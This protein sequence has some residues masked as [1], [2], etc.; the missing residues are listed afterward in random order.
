MNNLVLS[1]KVF[2]MVE[3]VLDAE[4][5]ALKIKT[6]DIRILWHL[7]KSQTALV[8]SLDFCQGKIKE[9]IRFSD[10]LNGGRSKENTVRS[11]SKI[12]NDLFLF[13]LESFI[14]SLSIRIA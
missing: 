7:I 13:S 10:N 14:D 2:N 11:N 3:L 1:D 6:D 9:R 5:L 12:K 8:S 4:P